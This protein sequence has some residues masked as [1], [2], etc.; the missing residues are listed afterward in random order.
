MYTAGLQPFPSLRLISSVPLV[1]SCSCRSMSDS[2]REYLVTTVVDVTGKSAGVASAIRE[3]F[4]QTHAKPVEAFLDG[5]DTMVLSVVITRDQKVSA[6][7]LS[8]ADLNWG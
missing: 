7:I 3:A 5:D 1:P 2:R 6:C 4:E 8:Y